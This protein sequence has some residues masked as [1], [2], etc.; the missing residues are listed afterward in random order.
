MEPLYQIKNIKHNIWQVYEK[1]YDDEGDQYLKP[2]FAG[3]ICDCESY[4]R[5]KDAGYLKD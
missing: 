3:S 1:T 5:L 4:I 2:V